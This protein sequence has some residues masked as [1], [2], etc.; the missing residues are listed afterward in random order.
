MKQLMEDDPVDDDRKA[1]PDEQCREDDS[2]G[3]KAGARGDLRYAAGLSASISRL[4]A[5]RLSACAS[6]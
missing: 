4:T 2:A 3:V 5:S 6:I 1:D